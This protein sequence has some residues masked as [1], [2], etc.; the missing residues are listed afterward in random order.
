MKVLRKIVTQNL[1][2]YWIARIRTYWF[3]LLTDH[4]SFTMTMEWMLS[5]AV[6]VTAKAWPPV[7]R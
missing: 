7:G 2:K 6:K 1:I 5:H 4:A 3:R